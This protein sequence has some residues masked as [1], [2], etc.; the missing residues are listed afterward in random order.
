MMPMIPTMPMELFAED[1]S[2]LIKM[3]NGVNE[4]DF[5]SYEQDDFQ[6]LRDGNGTIC[7]MFRVIDRQ[8]AEKENKDPFASHEKRMDHKRTPRSAPPIVDLLLELQLMM[9]YPEFPSRQ[10]SL[11]ANLGGYQEQYLKGDSGVFLTLPHRTSRVSISGVTD[12]KVP[13]PASLCAFAQETLRNRFRDAQSIELMRLVEH[14]SNYS[15]DDYIFHHRLE[16]L[17]EFF[18][19]WFSSEPDEIPELSF[20][21]RFWR[22]SCLVEDGMCGVSCLGQEGVV[23]GPVR[24]VEVEV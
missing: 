22:E 16:E 13:D 15:K 18:C 14:K 4:I 5:E 6:N 20:L 21:L 11:F 17:M 12:F 8:R 19:L 24:Y 1:K 23:Q 3:I 2:A 10:H 7:P 9:H